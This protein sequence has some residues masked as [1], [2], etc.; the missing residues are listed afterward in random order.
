MKTDVHCINLLSG[1]PCNIKD[2]QLQSL[3][4]FSTDN[5]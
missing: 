5:Y 1:K 3:S 4:R 2:V